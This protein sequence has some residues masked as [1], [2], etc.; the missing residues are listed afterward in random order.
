MKWDGKCQ[1]RKEKRLMH[2]R[3]GAAVNSPAGNKLEVLMTQVEVYEE[4]NEM[5]RRAP[6]SAT[7]K[8]SMR[9]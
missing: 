9:F 8:I 1:Y 3:G 6:P 7:L 2:K 4:K 5:C